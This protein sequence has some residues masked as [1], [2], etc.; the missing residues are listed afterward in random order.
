[1]DKFEAY[2]NFN[3]AITC[4]LIF[5]ICFCGCSYINKKLGLENDNI[6]EESIERVI[7]GQLGLPKDSIDLTPGD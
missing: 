2:V 3:L 1:M 4:F 6:L 5:S 7:E